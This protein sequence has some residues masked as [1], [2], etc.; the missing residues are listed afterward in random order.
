MNTETILLGLQIL[1][2]RSAEKQEREEERERGEGSGG[3]TERV[4]GV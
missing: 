3:S 4:R 1:Q 2:E